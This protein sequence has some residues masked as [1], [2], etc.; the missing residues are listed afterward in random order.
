MHLF[1]TS[2]LFAATLLTAA[3]PIALAQGTKSDSKVKVTATADKPDND[4]KQVVN[5]VLQIEKGWHVYAN[6]VGNK[7]LEASQTVVSVTA[8]NKPEVQITYPEGVLI[9]DKV[10]GDYKVYEDK[11]TI[12]A[13]V[14]RAK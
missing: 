13:T 10:V 5:L 9:P 2:C 8:K 11:V 4:G 7:D 12:K 1:R 14:K 3:T 6:P